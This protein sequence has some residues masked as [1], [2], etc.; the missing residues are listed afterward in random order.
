VLS[1]LTACSTNEFCEVVLGGLVALP[2]TFI[3]LGTA[4]TLD[5]IQG[6]SF[7]LGFN[8]LPA[9]FANMPAGNWFGAIWFF[10]LFLAGVTSSLSMLQPA[11]AFLEEGFGL[12]RRVSVASLGLL[13]MSGA[14][15]VIYF[16]KGGGVALGTMDFWVGSLAIFVL[17][18]I[19]VLVFG[20]V[21]GIDKGLEEAKQGAAFPIPR[22]FGP[23]LKF[24]TPAFLLGV[25]GMWVYQNLWEQVLAVM[26]QPTALL[27]VLYMLVVLLFLLLLIALA[28]ER[29]KNLGK[30]AVEEA[31][32][33]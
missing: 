33:A 12:S 17:A 29:W 2:A 18:T 27:T 22:I 31:E 28:G 26:K 10:L 7:G 8:T 32:D 9:V 30:G 24:V 13:T 21:M 23:I 11:I 6:N 1:S 16:S 15:A 4:T 3:F 19:Q 5:V 25:F 20:W 14:L